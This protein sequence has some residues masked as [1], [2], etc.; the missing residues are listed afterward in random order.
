VNAGGITWLGGGLKRLRGFNSLTAK[1][2]LHLAKLVTQLERR[3]RHECCRN[4]RDSRLRVRVPPARIARCAVAQ[5]Q[6]VSTFRSKLSCRSRRSSHTAVV[7]NAIETTLAPGSNPGGRANDR[8]IS[9]RSENVPIR[10]VVPVA[11]AENRVLT[12]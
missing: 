6:R 4:Y 7:A 11:V 9:W 5:R 2:V 10:I 1:A 8:T 12:T 3:D